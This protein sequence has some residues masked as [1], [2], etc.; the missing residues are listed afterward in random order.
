MAERGILTINA[1]DGAI[2]ATISHDADIADEFIRNALTR[3]YRPDYPLTSM[4]MLLHL[5]QEYDD[6]MGGYFRER[7]TEWLRKAHYV[8]RDEGSHVARAHVRNLVEMGFDRARWTVS[9]E[10]GR[11]MRLDASARKS[12]RCTCRRRA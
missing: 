7:G 5:N 11:F 9:T 1:P 12:K 8:A 6:A 3:V 2:I 10:T 4:Q